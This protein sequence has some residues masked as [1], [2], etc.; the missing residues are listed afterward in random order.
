M[1]NLATKAAAL[2]IAVAATLSVFL[3]S[4]AWGFAQLP[5]GSAAIGAGMIRAD[6]GV[7]LESE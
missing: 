3:A 4:P 7:C 1:M 6:G 5:I 2:A